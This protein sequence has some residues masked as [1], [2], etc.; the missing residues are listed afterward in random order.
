MSSAPHT[1]LRYKERLLTPGPTT[2]PHKV[3]QAM[4]IPM[5][6]HRS[7]VFK[8]E[9]LA[10]CSGVR[11][12]LGW[13]SDPVFL[14]S[15]GTGALEAALLNTCRQGEKIIYVNG[16]AFGA[17]WGAIA[18]RL[19]L[20]THEVPVAWGSGVSEDQILD[21]CRLHPEAKAVCL[22]HS[23]TSTTVLHPL[24]E[25]LP[26][27]KR[28][29]PEA[30][31][32]VDAISASVTTPPPGTPETVDVYIA[33]SQKA[34][35]LPPGLSFLLLSQG[36]WRKVENT[37][38]RSLYFDLLLE[39]KC[40]SS[41]ETAW[42]PA[43]TLIVGLNAA[44]ALINEEGLEAVYA[45][46]TLLSRIARKG[47]VALGCSLLSVDFPCPSVTGLHLPDTLI[48]KRVTGDA[49]RSEVRKRFGVRLAGGQGQWK[50]GAIRIGHMGFVDPF[51]VI[52]GISALGL[53][54]I[55][56]GHPVHLSKVLESVM[57]EL[58]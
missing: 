28:E 40:L 57:S 3:L 19:G 35:M 16:G 27:I 54:L 29:L 5:L 21:A 2:I 36:A 32:I 12:L 6:H 18:E 17:R 44:I 53:T 52:D 1:M 22:Q 31:T 41:G 26:I 39:R 46:H 9:L 43:S 50:G 55:E 14:A 15:S 20:I 11:A 42:T 13:D 24:K 7:D 49:I 8:K 38:K 4:Q 10:A 47:V 30:L 56:A 34:Y 23:E 33:G 58:L 45:R 48:K 25:L 51:D 37:P